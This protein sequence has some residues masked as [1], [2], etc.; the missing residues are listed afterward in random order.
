MKL[1]VIRHDQGNR[2]DGDELE[3]IE[4]ILEKSNYEE[5]YSESVGFESRMMDPISEESGNGNGNYNGNGKYCGSNNYLDSPR[6]SAGIIVNHGARTHNAGGLTLKKKGELATI[7]EL[8]YEDVRTPE[9]VKGMREKNAE[10]IEDFRIE[11]VGIL[12]KV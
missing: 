4:N 9:Y 7:Q 8:I 3:R 6:S 5:G 10:D 11:F 12:P 2:Y 1:N